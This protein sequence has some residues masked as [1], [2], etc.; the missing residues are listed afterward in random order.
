MLAV[1][2]RM[3]VLDALI[4][5]VSALYTDLVKDVD[6]AGQSVGSLPMRFGSMQGCLLSGT[7]FALTLDAL[8]RRCMGTIMFASSRLCAVVDDMRL[9][10][11]RLAS[12]LGAVL[13]LFDLGGSP[14]PFILTRRNASSSRPAA[15]TPSGKS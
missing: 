4:A 10:L 7:L 14:V 6:F 8:I 13:S 11:A 2:R 9:V 1:L 3:C 12:Q 15:S 5:F